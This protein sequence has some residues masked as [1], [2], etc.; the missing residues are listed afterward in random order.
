M[1]VQ[2]TQLYEQI[3]G[4]IVELAT[5][6]DEHARVPA[7]PDWT[8]RDLV[9]H[10]VGVRS[11]IASG[12]T[13]G[14]ATDPWT[15]RQVDERAGRS[16]PEL[17]AEWDQLTAS[18]PLPDEGAPSA[19][20]DGSCHEQDLRGAVERPGARDDASVE[21]ALTGL[22]SMVKGK[23][24]EAGL[25]ALAVEYDG[26][27]TVVGDGEPGATVRG[28]TFELMRTVSGRR[29]RAQAAALSWTS[30]PKKYLDVIF[31]FGPAQ[32]DLNE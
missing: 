27:R 6:A 28:S 30:D 11:D 20:V 5:G 26:S 13:E 8:V 2:P 12:N 21:F 31:V 3:R 24:A 14:A 16:V 25:P 1:D 18:A 4:R 29:S 19:A 22:L 17:V 15:Q 9:A 10:L 32:H 7:T 23:L